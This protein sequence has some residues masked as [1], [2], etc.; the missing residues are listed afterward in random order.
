MSPL[1]TVDELKAALAELVSA[2]VIGFSRTVNIAEVGFARG[3][4]ETWLHAQ[5]PF[6]V[7]RGESTWFGTVDMA[8]PG[9]ADADPDEAYRKNETMFDKRARQVSERFQS[10]EY[11][12][13]AATLGRAGTITLVLT[14]AVV[15]DIFPASGGPI[16]Q[17]RLFDRGSDVHYVFPDAAVTG[18]G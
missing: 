7:T 11:V 14:G 6:R 13:E 5:C 8:Y 9:T 4:I 17:W 12:V 18:S 3:E 15:I 10:V 1:S 2:R 16:E